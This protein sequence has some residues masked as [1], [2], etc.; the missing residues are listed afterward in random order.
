MTEI[1]VKWQSEY[2]HLLQV[3]VSFKMYSNKYHITLHKELPYLV[4]KRI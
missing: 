4:L 3:V 1:D 2:A